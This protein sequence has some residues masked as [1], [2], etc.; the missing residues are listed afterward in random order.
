[1]RA[2]LTA[3]LILLSACGTGAPPGAKGSCDGAPE[4]S[5]QTR[6]R[7]ASAT[8]PY[9]GPCPSETQQRTC[10]AG[11]WSAWSGTFQSES[12]QVAA[13]ADCGATPNGGTESRTCYGADVV[14]YGSTCTGSTQTRT[15][16]D[17]AWSSPPSLRSRRGRAC[18]SAAPAATPCRAR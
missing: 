18:A 16:G 14:P 15:C 17:G 10:S 1:M 9:P 2:T 13:A 5:S 12:C 7:Y 3:T 4:G 6:V 11:T 8:A